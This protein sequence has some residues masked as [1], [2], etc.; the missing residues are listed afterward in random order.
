ML[1]KKMNLEIISWKLNIADEFA[2]FNLIIFM[3]IFYCCGIPVLIPLAFVNLFSKYITNRSLLQSL[4][5]RVS[6]LSEAFNGLPLT[7]IPIMLAIACLLGS[8]MLTANDMV[9]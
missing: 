9:I 5:S 1:Q 4:S 7:I 6:G 3:A 8:W 2:Y